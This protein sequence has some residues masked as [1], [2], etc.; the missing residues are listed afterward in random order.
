MSQK[1]KYLMYFL[2][3]IGNLFLPARIYAEVKIAA[4][5]GRL[6]EVTPV[7]NPKTDYRV[8]LLKDYLNKNNSILSS[9]AQDFISAAD[10]NGIPW[11]L[12]PAIAGVESTF[13]N[14]VPSYST[15][16]WGWNNG[17]Y[18]FVNYKEAIS[19]VSQTL[20]RNYFDRGLDTPE[21]IAHV[22]APPSKTWAG[23]VRFFMGK[24]ENH[25]TSIFP[26][27]LISG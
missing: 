6:K 25:Q 7:E 1:I 21:K 2:F 17:A 15:N 10:E 12:V 20:K 13:C 5:S 9:Y 11:S 18:Q 26:Q 24:I 16:C 3:F 8:D 27:P 4:E 23:K 14:A 22:Y 19:T